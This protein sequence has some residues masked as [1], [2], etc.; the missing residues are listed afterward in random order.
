MNFFNTDWIKIITM[1]Y[2]KNFIIFGD[3]LHRS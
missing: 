2:F 1:E 3:K